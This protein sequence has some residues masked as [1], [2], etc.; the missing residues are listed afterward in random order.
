MNAE[1]YDI[2]QMKQAWIEMGKA[3]GIDM[4]PCDPDNFNKIKTSLE[5]L[6]DRYRKACDFS[7]VGA[8]IFTILIFFMPSLR[9]EYRLSVAITFAFV[10]L[11]NAYAQYLLWRGVGKINPLIMPITQVSSMAKHYKKCHILYIILGSFVA[12]PWIAYFLYAIRR[13]GIRD[14]DGIVGGAII[15]GICG[16]YGLWQY[17]RDYRNLN[18]E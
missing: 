4:R 9:E 8:I 12:I 6:R 18:M 1:N 15:G 17:L 5:R 10:M 2:K 11:A 14:T 3:L 16:L 13:S 7:I